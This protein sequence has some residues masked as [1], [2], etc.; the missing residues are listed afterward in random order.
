M[1]T[2]YIYGA[3]IYI[4][5]GCTTSFEAALLD[6]KIVFL[7]NKFNNSK[8]LYEKFGYTIDGKN[9]NIIFDLINNKKNIT[10]S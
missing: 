9:T 7:K 1:I 6:K 8:R 4:H 2:P 3:E 5:S 10:I